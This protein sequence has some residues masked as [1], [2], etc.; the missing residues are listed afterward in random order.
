MPLRSEVGAL[1]ALRQRGLA[2]LSRLSAR[3]RM[4]RHHLRC[5]RDSVDERPKAARIVGRAEGQRSRL[6]DFDNSR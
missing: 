3:L 5:T 1:S 4:N 2:D 6:S